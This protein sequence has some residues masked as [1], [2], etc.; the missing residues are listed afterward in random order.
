MNITMLGAV[1]PLGASSAIE[2]VVHMPEL[3]ASR[4][5]CTRDSRQRQ[6]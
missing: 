3:L 6:G 2:I 1:L 4:N 5:N